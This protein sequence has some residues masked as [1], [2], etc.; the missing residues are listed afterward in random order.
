[1]EEKRYLIECNSLMVGATRFKDKAIQKAFELSKEKKP[2]GRYNI[3]AVL[4]DTPY[5]IEK[6]GTGTKIVMFRNGKQVE[7]VFKNGR[8]VTIERNWNID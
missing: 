7:N 4:E 1:M 3:T 8:V 5:K 2:N 6:I